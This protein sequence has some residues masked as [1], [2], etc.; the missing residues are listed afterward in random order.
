MQPGDFIITPSWT[1][2][3][4]G[5]EATG[6]VVWLDGLDI[7]LVRFLDAGFAENYLTAQ[8]PVA[9]SEG[10]AA[11]RYAANMLPLDYDAPHGRTSPIFTYPYQRARE[12]LATLARGED[13][14]P[15]HGTKLRYVNPATGGYPTPTIAAFLQLLPPGFAGRPYRSTEGSVFCVAEGRGRARLGDEVFAYSQHDVFVAPSWTRIALEAEV[16]SVLFSFSD[17]P[18]HEALGVLRE[19]KMAP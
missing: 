10:T 18:V 14:D 19:E 13:A 1:W 15:W 3:D 8:Q 5:N 9:R 2:H 7:P 11:A 16:E 6:P 12:A 4:H 17:R